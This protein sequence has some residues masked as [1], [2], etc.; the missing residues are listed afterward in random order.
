MCIRDRIIQ[1]RIGGTGGQDLRVVGVGV[2]GGLQD[3]L[4]LHALLAQVVF[5]QELR[6]AAQHDV[7]TTAG[8]VGGDGHG[9]QLARLGHDLGL[10]FMVLGVQDVVGDALFFQQLGQDLGLFNGDGAHQHGLALLV[11]LLNL[12]DNGAELARLGLVNH[13]GVI[14]KSL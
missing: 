3:Q 10:F 11:A 9:P 12:V 6:V 7:G 8:H 5:R 14:Q 1:L 13:V 4:L 2:G